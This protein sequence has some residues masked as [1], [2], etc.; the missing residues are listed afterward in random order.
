[1]AK[2]LYRYGQGWAAVLYDKVEIPISRDDY[3]AKGYQP[4]YEELPTQAQYGGAKKKKAMADLERERAKSPKKGR[5]DAH[6]P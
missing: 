4:P 1:M 5:P 3:V 6:R 2:G